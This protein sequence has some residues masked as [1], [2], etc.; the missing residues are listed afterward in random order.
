MDLTLATMR[1][2]LRH[3]LATHPRG[4]EAID[5]YDC[6]EWLLLNGA[7][8]A[9]GRLRLP[10]R[11]LRPRLRVRGRRPGASAARRGT[12]AARRSLRAFFTYRGAFFWK[13]QSGMGDIVFAPLYEVL[14]PAGC[15]LRV[16]PSPRE[17]RGLAWGEDRR[18]SRR[19]SST[20]RRAR[21]RGAPYRAARRCA[22]TAVLA[23]RSRCGT[24]SRRHRSSCAEGRDFETFLGP[25]TV[26]D[27]GC[28]WATDFDLVV[29]GW[30]SEP[31]RMSAARSSRAIPAGERWSST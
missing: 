11:A 17:R 30:A 12:G 16:L 18:T 25:V 8:A 9:V 22:W 3:N 7:S 15:A 24:S 2:I 26:T 23:R 1:G 31:S 13:M 21:R 6:R 19:S 10:A 20:C 28:A 5:D 29:L 27:D 4:F 14:Q